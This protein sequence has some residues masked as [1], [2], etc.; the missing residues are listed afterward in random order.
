MA[1]Q[2]HAFQ[3]DHHPSAFASAMDWP[4]LT[5]G[6]SLHRESEGKVTVAWRDSERERT[7]Q[8]N[9]LFI[10]AIA[11]RAWEIAAPDRKEI[12]TLLVEKALHFRRQCEK[13]FRLIVFLVCSFCRRAE[14]K[15]ISASLSCPLAL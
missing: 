8:A 6:G 2:P 13:K 7:K 5:S 3:N 10:R 4:R 15:R 9:S 11:L 12:P 1:P 14:E